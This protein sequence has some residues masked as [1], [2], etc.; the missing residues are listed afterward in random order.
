MQTIVVG[1]DGSDASRAALAWAVDEAKLRNATLRVVH[2]WTLT[3]LA[4]PSFGPGA[5]PSATDIEALESASR[6][7]LAAAVD[8]VTAAEP[9]LPVEQSLV[10]GGAAQAL[11]AESEHADLLVVGSRGHGGFAELLLGSVSHQCASHASCPVVIVRH[12]GVEG[13]DR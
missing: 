9:G 3:P 11:L 7:T 13:A 5:F 2:A 10:R 12:I 8:G 1:F 4:S 6:D